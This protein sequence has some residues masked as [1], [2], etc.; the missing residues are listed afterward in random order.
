MDT[1]E[2]ASA[3]CARPLVMAFFAFPDDGRR[4]RRG[5]R[6]FAFACFW[7][8]LAS[9]RSRFADGRVSARRVIAVVFFCAAAG[10]G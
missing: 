1:L 9:H 10:S 8:W 4:L 2:R 7:S 5:R 3:F 6:R